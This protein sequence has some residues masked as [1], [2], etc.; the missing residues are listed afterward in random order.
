MGINGFDREKRES[1]WVCVPCGVKF[2]SKKQLESEGGAHTAHI[3]E[4]CVCGKEDSVLH[5]RNYNWL[6]K[7]KDKKDGE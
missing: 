3:G 2:L 6:H 1:D 4:C 7:P 5:I